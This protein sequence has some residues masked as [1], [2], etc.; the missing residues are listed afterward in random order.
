[1]L[2]SPNLPLL[3]LP[4]ALLQSTDLDRDPATGERP[5]TLV[6]LPSG[7][8]GVR[9]TLNALVRLTKIY[10]STVPVRDLAERIIAAVGEKDYTSEVVAVQTWV[11]DSVRYTR[12]VFDVETLKTPLETIRSLQGDCDDKALLAGTLLQSIGFKVRYVAV[13]YG[14]PDAYDHVYV[15]TMLGNHWIAVET[16]ENVSLGWAPPNPHAKMI[17]NV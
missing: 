8:A 12:D 4:L 17:G 10:R 14:E 7:A 5:N 16:T 11:R 2:A 9:A 3:A 13:G 1:M 15:E 6:A